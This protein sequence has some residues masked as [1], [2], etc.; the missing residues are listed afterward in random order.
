MSTGYDRSPTQSSGNSTLFQ[1]GVELG[2]LHQKMDAHGRAL[3]LLIQLLQTSGKTAPS[4]KEMAPS[5][6]EATATIPSPVENMVKR[7]GLEALRWLLAKIWSVA[8]PYLPPAL[9]F[10]W[11]TLN[12]LGSALWRWISPILLSLVKLWP[13]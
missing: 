5:A 11:A 2:R 6:T 4:R 3:D 9:L 8:W 12:G 10:I 1:I 13:F 7:L